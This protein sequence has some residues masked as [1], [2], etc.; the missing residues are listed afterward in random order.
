MTRT[1]RTF[2]LAALVLALAALAAAGPA[3]A[4]KKKVHGTITIA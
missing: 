1:I 3:A 4:K 2:G